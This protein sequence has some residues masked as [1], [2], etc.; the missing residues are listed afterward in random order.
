MKFLGWLLLVA[1]IGLGTI[2]VVVVFSVG[3]SLMFF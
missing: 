3:L 2:A 1:V